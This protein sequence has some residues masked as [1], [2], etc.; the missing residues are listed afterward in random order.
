[1]K[2]IE[3]LRV[4]WVLPVAWFYWHPVLSNFTKLFPDTKIFTGLWPGF[5]HGFENSFPVEEVGKMNYLESSQT[6]TGYG[7]GFTYLSPKIIG[8]LLQFKPDIIFA[9]SFRIWTI[10][11]LFLKPL[12]GWQV[13]LTYEGSSPSVDYRNSA[14]RTFLRRA[15]VKAADAYITN[16]KA[17][18]DYLTEFLHADESRVFSMPYEVPDQTSLLGKLDNTGTE[19]SALQ[20]PIFFF[21]GH[22]VRRKGVNFLLQACALL[23]K[24]GH[25]DYTLLVAGD[26]PERVELE[27]FCETHNLTDCVKLLGKVDYDSLGTYFQQ[28][29]VFVLPTLEDTWGMVVLEAM[30]F[31]KPVLCSQW[32]GTAEMIVDGEN[33]YVF[34]PHQPEKLAEFMLWF[35][36]NRSRIHDMGEKSQQIMAEHSPELVSQSLKNVIASLLSGT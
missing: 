29:D 9:D 8:K 2:R 25:K 31:G 20:K 10:F 28:A 34:D 5:A 21:V 16:S 11:V 24:Q 26:G 30:L 33:G 7:T 19:N 27:A 12:G 35:M 23:Q 32:A 22:L 1:M 4:A 36:N 18:K 3:N 17:G 15:M 6:S 13:I 14:L